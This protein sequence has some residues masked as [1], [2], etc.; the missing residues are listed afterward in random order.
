MRRVSGKWMGRLVPAIAVSLLIIL[1]AC[2][3]HVGAVEKAV[4]GGDP[5]LGREAI[6]RHGCGS[7]HTIPGVP[8]ADTYVGPPLNNFNLRH[9]IAGLLPNTADN[10]ILWIQFPQSVEPGTAMP[11]LGVSEIDARDIAAYLYSQS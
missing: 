11:D 4:P 6:L 8:G 3:Q 2:A 7:C 1:S 9:Y 10:L 5:A